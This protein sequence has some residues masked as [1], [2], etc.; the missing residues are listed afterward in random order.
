MTNIIY[1]S[2][3]EIKEWT[4]KTCKA[5]FDEFSVPAVAKR[6]ALQFI[7]KIYDKTASHYESLPKVNSETVQYTISA[8]WEKRRFC[9]TLMNPRN[10]DFGKAILNPIDK[11]D[12]FYG[13]ALAFS[14]MKGYSEYQ[15]MKRADEFELKNGQSIYDSKQI[16]YIFIGYMPSIK[17]FGVVILPEGKLGTINLKNFYVK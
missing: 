16:P 1:T 15:L 8:F 3:K 4:E 6:T 7:Q 13:I 2:E 10:G 5:F 17:E 9:I 14:R 12:I 11:L